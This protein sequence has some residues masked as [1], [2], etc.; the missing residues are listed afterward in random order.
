MERR[1]EHRPP[2]QRLPSDD[3]RRLG[4]ATRDGQREPFSSL[5]VLGLASLT[6]RGLVQLQRAAGNHAVARLVA[7]YQE[8][9]RRETRAP[10]QSDAVGSTPIQ[11]MIHIGDKL[12]YSPAAIRQQLPGKKDK[13]VE[14]GQW[15]KN[16]I[17]LTQLAAS[18]VENAFAI[19]G[20]N[21]PSAALGDALTDKLNTG[22]TIYHYGSVGQMNG[23]W[24]GLRGG[25]AEDTSPI[26]LPKD[27]LDEKR[28]LTLKYDEGK[29]CVLQALINLGITHPRL[30]AGD[31]KDPKAWH[32]YYVQNDVMYDDDTVLYK[33]YSGFGLRMVWNQRTNWA[34]LSTQVI[35]PGR[36]VFTTPGH[37][38]AVNVN[39]NPDPSKRYEPIDTPQNIVT[40]YEA[41]RIISYVWRYQ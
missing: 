9:Q 18:P 30:G 8:E 20:M 34:N 6:P 11:R 28:D 22:A 23:F 39:D 26:L 25:I 17:D 35:T 16:L 32:T 27:M 37:N 15:R 5:G 19:P 41:N 12:F 7:A 38:F 14:L 1:Q 24:R 3:P 40:S 21:V 31:Q 29:A 33:I 4:E 13:D 10:S 36:Y 2:A